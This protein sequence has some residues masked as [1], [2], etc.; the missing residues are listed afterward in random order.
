M[1]ERKMGTKNSK[2]QEKKEENTWALL[3]RTF[4]FWKCNFLE[5]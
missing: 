1:H 3:K 4:L 5:A 2:T